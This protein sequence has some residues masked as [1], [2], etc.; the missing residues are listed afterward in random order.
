MNCGS[1]GARDRTFTTA[2]LA[3][4]VPPTCSPRAPAPATHTCWYSLTRVSVA[5]S[6]ANLHGKRQS[7]CGN[8]SGHSWRWLAPASRRV[9]LPVADALPAPISKGQV[10]AGDHLQGR[11]GDQA[12]RTCVVHLH[13]LGGR[14]MRLRRAAATPPAHLGR[15]GGA[16]HEAV[17]P[18]GVRVA[19]VALVPVHA[20]DGH[21]DGERGSNN[22]CVCVC[23]CV[24]ATRWDRLSPGPGAS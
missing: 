21:L 14:N 3:H 13:F 24:S 1:E 20:V 10:A 8:E 22:R 23:V 5:S 17:W 12:Q 7:K 2:A 16:G 19:P 6:R 15:L 18:K 11:A 9:A 4:G